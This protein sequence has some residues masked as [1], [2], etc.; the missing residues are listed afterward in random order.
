MLVVFV[1]LVTRTTFLF[2]PISFSLSRVFPARQIEFFLIFKIFFTN[3]CWI[4]VYFM[5]RLITHI[6]D[7]IGFKARVV[8]LPA[9]F[10]A[11]T[12][13]SKGHV[14]CYTCLLHQ[15][16]AMGM[17]P[18]SPI[19][20]YSSKHYT[21]VPCRSAIKNILSIWLVLE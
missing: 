13:A 12:G 9:L 1:L 6:F 17:N 4:K 16:A 3:F 7:P 11:C 19:T 2:D 15:Q 18:G 10:P 21:T 14:W 20:Q 8:L 5:G